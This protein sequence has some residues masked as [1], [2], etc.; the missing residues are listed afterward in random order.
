MSSTNNAKIL[1][2]VG[3]PGAGKSEAVEHICKK[4][5]PKVYFG[6]IVLNAMKES[7]IEFSEKNER[8]F[9][10]KLR[11]SEGNDFIVRRIIEEIKKLIQ[12]GQ[13]K[14]VADGLY[15]W[16]EYKIMKHEFPGE[17]T[18]VAV[19]APK[20]VRHQR[21][22][23]RPIRPLTEEEASR[24]DWAQIE[25]LNQGGPIAVADYY[26]HNEKN[27]EDLQSSLDEICQKIEF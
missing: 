1:A 16:E 6:G 26:V 24:R 14:I 23:K 19:V 17:M 15:S 10:E 9:R 18:V 12:A 21:L 8:E 22:S 27:I 13:H 11:E 7:G 4:G 3:L 20:K 2:V 25:T 5:V